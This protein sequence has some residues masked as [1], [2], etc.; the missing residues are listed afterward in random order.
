MR[1]LFNKHKNFLIWDFLLITAT[2][3]VLYLFKVAFIGDDFS[4]NKT[5]FIVFGAPVIA[6]IIRAKLGSRALPN[7]SDSN[8]FLFYGYQVTY[9]FGLLTL[10]LYR[11]VHEASIFLRAMDSE[12]DYRPLVANIIYVVYLLVM[13]LASCIFIKLSTQKSQ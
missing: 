6:C 2:S 3:Q 1:D 10:M 7:V 11:V 4:G 8:K 5:S 13:F 12:P 9:A